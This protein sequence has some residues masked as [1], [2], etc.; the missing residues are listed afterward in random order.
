ML[1]ILKIYQDTKKEYRWQL[2]SKANN[3]IVVSSS[4]GFR[5]QDGAIENLN[6]SAIFLAEAV[7]FLA[8]QAEENEQ[9]EAERLA[10]AKA[11]L[12]DTMAKAEV[13][14]ARN[15]AQRANRESGVADAA[16]VKATKASVDANIAQADA[17]QV[18][19]EADAASTAAISNADVT[20]K[21]LAALILE[22]GND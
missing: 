4:E 16:A 9:T 5:S 1:S 20:S 21:A 3:K 19:T 7:T 22:Q 13:V 18:A 10:L 2:R 6:L 14:K 12:E 15:A 11:R 17:S 8:D